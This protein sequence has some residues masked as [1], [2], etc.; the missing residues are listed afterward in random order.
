M[1]PIALML[2]C[3]MS[4]A[5]AAQPLI[6]EHNFGFEKNSNPGKLPDQW[7]EWGKGYRLI[8]DSVTVHSG[9]RSLLIEPA[10]NTAK[11]FGAAGY[12][13]TEQY[14]AREIEV[15]AHM[16]LSDVKDG[17]IG[18]MLRID[19]SSPGSFGFNNMM[20]K[21]IQGT[22]DWTLYSVKLPYP[23]EE[24]EV[25]I[26]AILSGTGKLW[27]DDFEV[28]LDGKNISEVTSRKPKVFKA[29]SDHEFDRGSNIAGITLNTSK[30]EDLVVLGKVWGFLKYHHPAVASGDLNWDYEL[31]RVLPKVLAS[32]NVEERNAILNTWVKGLGPVE[33][34]VSQDLPAAEVKAKP[35]LAWINGTSLGDAL[36]TS[37]HEVLEA[38]R[39]NTNYYIAMTGGVG[40]PEFKNEKPYGYN[41]YPDQGLRLLTV[42]RYWNMIQYFFPYKNL[43]DGDWNDVLPEYVPRFVNASNTI[44]YKLATL[45]MI[46]RIHDTHANIWGGDGDIIS[47]KGVRL[48]PVQIKF[49]EN[50]AVVA[51]YF[52]D[53]LGANSGLKTGDI[54]E[55]VNGKSVDDIIKSRLDLTPASNYPTQL[56]D[57]AL[58]ILRTNDSTLNIKY[59]R[60]SKLHAAKITTYD[61]DMMKPFAKFMTKDTCFRMI[62]P[63]IAYLY[64]GTLKN[65]YLPAIMEKVKNTK[66]LIIDFRCYPADFT[67]FTLSEYLLPAETD[68]VKWSNGSIVHPGLF[69]MRE[70]TKAGKANADSYKGKV[71]IIVNEKTQSSAEYHTMAFRTAPGAAVIGST[72]AGAD[73]NVSRIVLP[74][75][76]RTM[77]SGIGVYYPDGRETQRV[78]IVPDIE[79][80]PTIKGIKEGKDEP[81][82][83]AISIINGK[84]DPVK[85]GRK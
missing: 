56:R 34:S 76:I 35:D 9:K 40:N 33:K 38:K 14:D 75:G 39:P 84:M 74:G 25:F 70:G 30:T 4:G 83:K 63:N 46:G 1:R 51:S 8:T 12:K 73:G 15:R 77:I 3:L 28:L 21:N 13:I 31:F 72:T 2:C 59:R 5:L 36:N 47:F 52:D 16:K 23:E 57:M 41:S 11:Q 85:T 69:T 82:D 55:E 49:I 24:N 6:P 26:G 66:G 45:S 20:E 50:K 62:S 18:L 48:A 71:V 54:I 22:S 37:L 65:E 43:I 10:P 27:V 78:G 42:Y 7:M 80:K 58:D 67:V 53:R 29:S 79:V 32:Q 61:S 17:A 64:P 19:G 60:D 81:L 44:E 68:F